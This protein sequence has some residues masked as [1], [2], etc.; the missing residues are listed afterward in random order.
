M[1]SQKDYGANEQDCPKWLGAAK[2]GQFEF[3]TW[4]DH[5]TFREAA[6]TSYTTLEEKPGFNVMK[7]LFDWQ[8]LD[9]AK[10]RIFSL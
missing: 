9:V 6:G 4:Y 8:R 5:Q 2:I 3:A 10:Y 1:N 7:I